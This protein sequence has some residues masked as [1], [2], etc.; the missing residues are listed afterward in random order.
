MTKVK[1]ED[2]RQFAGAGKSAESMRPYIGKDGKFYVNVYKGGPR[3]DPKNYSAKLVT[4]ATLRYDEWRA[5]DDAV[6]RAGMQRLAGFEDLRRNG[7]VYTLNNPMATTVLTYERL[8][9]AMEAEVNINPVRRTGGDRVVFEQAHIPIP[10]VHSDYQIGERQ[11]QESRTRGNGLDVLN[12]EAAARKVAE[13]LEDMLFGATSLKTYGGGVIYTYQTEPNINTVTLSTAWDTSGVT[14]AQI[15][16]DVIAM[17]QASID[18]RHYGP[19]MLYIP[20]SYDTILDE[21]YSVSGSSMQTIRQRITAIEGIQGVKVVDRLTA[22]TCLLVQ[23]TTDVVDLV[24]GMPIQNVEWATEGG[25]VHNYKVMT[26]QVPRVKSDY[27]DRSGI[28]KLS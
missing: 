12:A 26:I 13:K 24:D 10:V 22:D 16:A 7:L 5:L 6:L 14:A 8:S 17:K 18:D 25:F 28:V 27:N 3:S 15:L 4:N 20:T 1:V 19:W 11:L 9:E 21:D 2:L 23:M